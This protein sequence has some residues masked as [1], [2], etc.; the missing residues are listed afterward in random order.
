MDFSAFKDLLNSEEKR[1]LV[2]LKRALIK[3]CF[4]YKIKFFDRIENVYLASPF[5]EEVELKEEFIRMFYEIKQKFLLKQEELNKAKEQEEKLSKDLENL[6]DNK[7]HVCNASSDPHKDQEHCSHSDSEIIKQ[8]YCNDLEDNISDFHLALKDIFD[9]DVDND[10]DSDSSKTS[11]KDKRNSK[12]SALE[13]NSNSENNSID[14]IEG[15]KE[16]QEEVEVLDENN[17]LEYR[18]NSNSNANEIVKCKIENQ[19]KNTKNIVN[20]EFTTNSQLRDQ[21]M[22]LKNSNNTKNNSNNTCNNLYSS[23]NNLYTDSLNTQSELSK[24]LLEKKNH[25]TTEFNYLQNRKHTSNNVVINQNT[26]F[27]SN[28]PNLYLQNQVNNNFNLPNNTYSEMN[29]CIIFNNNINSLNNQLYNNNINNTLNGSNYLGNINNYYNSYSSSPFLG[30]NPSNLCSNANSNLNSNKSN[31]NNQIYLQPSLNNNVNGSNNNNRS[32]N[33]QVQKN[34]ITGIYQV[35]NNK[36][37]LYGNSQFSGNSNLVW[38]P[39]YNS[40]KHLKPFMGNTNYYGVSPCFGNMNINYINPNNQAFYS[41]MNINTGIS[42]NPIYNQSNMNNN[43]LN[44]SNSF[45]LNTNGNSQIELKKQE[46]NNNSCKFIGT[47]MLQ[48]NSDFRNPNLCFK[49]SNINGN[50]QS[51]QLNNQ[52]NLTGSNN[53]RQ[54]FFY[55]GEQNSML[56]QENNKCLILGNQVQSSQG[57]S[58]LL[59]V[60][61]TQNNNIDNNKHLK[62]VNVKWIEQLKNDESRIAENSTLCKKSDV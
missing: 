57:K 17:T 7:Y 30:Y 51:I 21:K 12:Y 46:I 19:G 10:D 47:Q 4:E 18:F 34:D 61:K 59:K 15:K 9:D 58:T 3:A 49:Q 27:K 32:N 6:I 20:Q 16:N 44:Q 23:N 53:I 38:P 25:K 56:P 60:S 52:N 62:N 55:G 48:Q 11:K 1:G 31:N 41:A 28:F 42:N 33:L 45:L 39:L 40:S 29:N 26:P 13:K 22:L 5:M 24:P 50:Y 14:N 36:N 54:D 35:N 43:Y 2:I 37:I 8:V